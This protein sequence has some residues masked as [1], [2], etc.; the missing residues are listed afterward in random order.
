MSHALL[1]VHISL[2]G[3]VIMFIEMKTVPFYVGMS[4]CNSNDDEVIFILNESVNCLYWE[5]ENPLYIH[6]KVE[7]N[8]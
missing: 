7:I 3:I 2:P 4:W 1:N 5:T 8:L 6:K